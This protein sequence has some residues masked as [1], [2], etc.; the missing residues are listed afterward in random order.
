MA[1]PLPL[2]LAWSADAGV[3]TPEAEAALVERART[4]R[5]AFAALYRAHYE[6]LGSYL[7]RRTGDAF[8]TE[9]LL[10]ETF[11]A[12]LKGIA[13][14]ESRGIP[15]RHWLYRIATRAA[16]RWARR[17]RRRREQAFDV[18]RHEPA[19]GA[20]ARAAPADEEHDR[21]VHALR[22]LPPRFQAVLVL[23]LVQGLALHEV[24]SVLRLRPG[25][26]KSRLSR[27]LARLRAALGERR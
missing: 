24:A 7:W 20:P 14:Y 19:A 18:E 5:R 4:D 13:R 3:V 27:G 11:L 9:D 15:F 1:T 6:A 21:A 8:A 26:V 22:A 23:H 10:G 16:N 25:T 2:S 12:A 17:G